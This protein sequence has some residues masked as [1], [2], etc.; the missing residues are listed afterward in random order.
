MRLYRRTH[1]PSALGP[2]WVSYTVLALRLIFC[3]W[4]LAKSGL[5]AISR[6]ILIL[7]VRA[8]RIWSRGTHAP[9]RQNRPR[10]RRQAIRRA[11]LRGQ[12]ER[13]V[14]AVCAGAGTGALSAQCSPFTAISSAGSYGRLSALQRKIP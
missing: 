10:N 12:G 1:G 5:V 3:R 2:L 6:F 7:P 11:C 4:N 8:A 9:F 13:T 14:A